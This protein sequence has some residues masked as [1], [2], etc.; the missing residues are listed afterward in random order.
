MRMRSIERHAK[1]GGHP[2]GATQD[3][4]SCNPQDCE[5]ACELSEWGPW[6]A[7][8]KKCDGGTTFKVKTVV[9]AAEGQGSCP[10]KHSKHRFHSRPCNLQPCLQKTDVGKTLK[11]NSK[12]DVVLLMDGSASLRT[13]GWTAM[14]A[15]GKAIAQAM[16]QDVN[17]A[18]IL[19]SGPKTRKNYFKCTGQKWPNR[20]TGSSLGIANLETDC[21][22]KWVHH[23][24]DNPGQVIGAIDN[25]QWPRGSSMLSEA[26]AMADSELSAG[27][28]DAKAVVVAI[29][30]GKPMNKRKV[31]E[32]VG[33]LRK[34]ARL[35]FYSVTQ[36]APVFLMKKWASW[37]VKENLIT[38]PNA[39]QLSSEANVNKVI[40]NMCESV[41]LE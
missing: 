26:L 12:L 15:A 20:K 22:V 16:G 37:P 3:V 38:V 34:K 13:S 6:S 11:C 36:N 17:L 31:E 2:C 18:A 28:K 29:T 1:H 32:M 24:T 41:E 35:M 27:R 25:L 7:C 4:Q 14:Q 33:Q 23:L 10:K 30:D 39:G 5:A 40:A 19:Y 8:S 21:L 9:K